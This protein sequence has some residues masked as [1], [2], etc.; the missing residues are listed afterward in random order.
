MPAHET[1]SRRIVALINQ[2]V[3]EIGKPK[4]DRMSTPTSIEELFDK[5]VEADFMDE[6]KAA[7]DTDDKNVREERWN[8]HDR[9][10]AREVSWTTTPTWTSI[11]RSFTYKFQ[12]K[13]VKAWLLEGHRVDGR[14]RERDPSS[15]RRGGRAAPGPRLR[16]VHPR[17]DPGPVRLPP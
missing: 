3:A 2:I 8:A 12:K 10:L 9:P 1:R 17:P 14:A 13:I 11:W 7:M 5:I 4:F 15:G 16:P 6:A